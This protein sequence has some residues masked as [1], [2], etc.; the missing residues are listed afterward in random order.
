MVNIN[1]ISL[2]PFNYYLSE[3]SSPCKRPQ[4]R[5]ALTAPSFVFPTCT[6]AR[7]ASEASHTP[8]KVPPHASRTARAPAEEIPRQHPITLVAKT[9]GSSEFAPR[10]TP[11]L[12]TYE[13]SVGTSNVVG[14]DVHCSA[15]S[16]QSSAVS[17]R[18]S[19]WNTETL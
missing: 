11:R 4:S 5:F 7:V 13:R 17:L 10:V 16:R 3:R 6:P 1:S 9:F 19:V 8:D 2:Q 18:Q 12:S 15:R 14:S